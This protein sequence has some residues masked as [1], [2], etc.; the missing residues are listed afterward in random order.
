MSWKEWS[1]W[2]RMY[3]KWVKAVG[4]KAINLTWPYLRGLYDWFLRELEAH[5]EVDPQ[6]ID[7]ESFLSYD[8][9][10]EEAKKILK[11]LMM[12]PPSER[13][14][15]EM[16]NEFKGMLEK[17]AH[18]KYPEI[19]GPL[20][21]KLI[22]LENKFVREKTKADKR[23]GE[24]KELESKLVE[25]ER[26][27][28]EARKKPPAAAPIR[29][30]I[31]QSF[32]EGIIDYRVGQVVETSSQEWALDKIQKGFA[33]RVTVGVTPPSF[34]AARPPAPIPTRLPTPRKELTREEERKLRDIFETTLRAGLPE[35]GLVGLS[36]YTYLP[37]FRR[38]FDSIKALR[39]PEEREG[40]IEEFA[41]DLV[42]RY[43]KPPPP[44]PKPAE[45]APP[46]W[47]KVTGGWLAPNGTFIKEEEMPEIQERMRRVMRRVPWTISRAIPPSP[48]GLN[49][50][51]WLIWEHDL[52]WGE[53]LKLSDPERKIL[54]DEYTKLARG[55]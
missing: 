33:E 22:D 42:R 9:S 24:I 16:Y 48:P 40:A 2:Q 55:G 53:F 29:L 12:V 39:T 20:E 44:P 26:L 43:A 10:I 15:E 46:G 7:V 19:L 34:P 5:P 36:P 35:E 4:A 49:L 54:L 32:S 38:E 31:L 21:D 41:K 6:A 1:T 37:E 25:T 11:S 23:L 3:D 52:T 51:D 50:K 18:E 28:E 8:I 17:Q 14:Y 45:A 27:L 30:R 47:A 13:E